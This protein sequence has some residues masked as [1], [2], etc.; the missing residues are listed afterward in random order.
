MNEALP[1][2]ILFVASSEQSHLDAMLV[3]A[4]HLNILAVSDIPKLRNVA[5]SSSL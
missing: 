4:S 3:A 2:S 1:C 5:E